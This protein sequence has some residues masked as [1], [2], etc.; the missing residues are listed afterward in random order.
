MSRTYIQRLSDHPGVPIAVILTVFY[1]YAMV[2]RVGWEYGVLGGLALSLLF[3]WSLVLW[4]N[5]D[6]D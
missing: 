3:P 1:V 5:F 4:S 6:R 2:E